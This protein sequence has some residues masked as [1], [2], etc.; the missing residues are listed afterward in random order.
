MSL[1]ARFGTTTEHEAGRPPRY[2][3]TCG[4]PFE[5]PADRPTAV[6]CSDDCWRDYAL[7]AGTD[8]VAGG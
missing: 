8:P 5:V 2:C 7:S 3:V 4:S 1:S 6:A